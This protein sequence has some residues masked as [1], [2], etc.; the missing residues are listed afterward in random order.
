MAGLS[1]TDTNR[2]RL[3]DARLERTGTFGTGDTGGAIRALENVLSTLGF[4]PGTVDGTFDA[5]TRG[6]LK[7]F[8]A[9]MGLE[10]TGEVD[11]KTLAEL[12]RALTGLRA[13]P[14]GVRRGQKGDDIARAER[15]LSRL[16]YDVGT[17]DGIADG[18]LGEAIVAFKKDQG[19][20]ENQAPVLSRAG[21]GVLDGEAKALQ[22][23]PWR[24]RRELTA[25]QHQFD[26]VLAELAKQGTLG[27][28]ARRPAIGQLQLRLRA[29]GFDP[30][31]TDG[32]F[33]ERTRGALEAFQKASGVE[34]TGVLD[35][36]TWRKL[37]RTIIDSGE[38][39]APVQKLGEKSG[40]VMRTEKLLQKAGFDPGELDGR[41][42]LQT[43]R[44]VRAFER[45][46][47][48]P[49]NGEVGER[50]LAGLKT[51]AANPFREPPSDYHRIA[52]RG[53]TVNVRTAEMVRQA[54]AWAQKHGVAPG[55]PIF[56]GSYN[57]TVD[58]SANTHAG[59]GAIDFNTEGRSPR[60]IHIMVE[61]LRRA[62]FAAWHRP[63]GSVAPEDH[64]HVIAIGDREMSSAARV[65]VREYFA[66]GDGLKGSAPDPHR[67]IGRPLP[68]WAKKFR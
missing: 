1:A 42:S 35:T 47:H 64:I 11:A 67:D 65:Q 10:P 48:R 29:A 60:T 8:Q 49:V 41:Y 51:L 28:G 14:E 50:D 15:Q 24:G 6:T 37:S 46:T 5:R 22:H 3:I 18:A 7:N 4:T 61:A 19:E 36:A 43:A 40:A 55:W 17:K 58:N 52:W 66:G 45:Q 23:A 30:Q 9:A 13:L 31:R 12:K 56:Q 32:V 27:E 34:A 63:P 39:A 16:G 57:T 33:D 21:L 54:E 26:G 68:E 2:L 53:H 25:Q 38:A 62:G 20:F 44:A 59:G